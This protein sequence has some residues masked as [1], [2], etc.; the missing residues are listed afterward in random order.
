[1]RCKD[2]DCLFLSKGYALVINWFASFTTIHKGRAEL[3]R[4]FYICH[5]CRKG[6]AVPRYPNQPFRRGDRVRLR[7]PFGSFPAGETGVI[8]EVFWSAEQCSVAFSDTSIAIVPWRLLEAA[9][10]SGT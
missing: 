10:D 2:Y 7:A 5:V 6:H 9:P 3:V 4:P 8:L 1:M